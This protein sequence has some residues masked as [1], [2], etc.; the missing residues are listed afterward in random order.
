MVK[1]PAPWMVWSWTTDPLSN[2]LRLVERD[3]SIWLDTT[4]N[5]ACESVLS[6]IFNFLTSQHFVQTFQVCLHAQIQISNE[7]FQLSTCADAQQI[8]IKKYIS[9]PSGK[10]TKNCGKSPFFMGRSTISM[11]IFTRFLYVYQRVSLLVVQSPP[12]PC[13]DTLQ[14]IPTSARCAR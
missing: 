3:G 2:D 1:I 14:F 11:A 4:R 6:S 10:H 13:Q 12:S 9:V 7:I 8:A 5:Y